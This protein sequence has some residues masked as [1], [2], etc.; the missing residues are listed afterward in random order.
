MVVEQSTVL[1]WQ[2]TWQITHV[3]TPLLLIVIWRLFYL[4]LWTDNR[5][6]FEHAHVS[7]AIFKH[8]E[9]V[10]QSQQALKLPCQYIVCNPRLTAERYSIYFLLSVHPWHQGSWEASFDLG[11]G[12]TVRSWTPV[13]LLFFRAGVDGLVMGTLTRLCIFL[14]P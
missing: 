3:A 2:I 9:R 10:T 14:Y 6:H 8:I 1:T 4:N 7:C 13:K 12:I 11:K 5:W